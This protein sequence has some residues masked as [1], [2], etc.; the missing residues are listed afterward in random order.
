MERGEIW[1]AQLPDH[2]AIIDLSSIICLN[3]TANSP[4]MIGSLVE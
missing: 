1:W 4:D 2:I 3:L